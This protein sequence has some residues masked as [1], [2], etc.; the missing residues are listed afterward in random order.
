MIRLSSLAY[1]LRLGPRRLVA[2]LRHLPSFLRLFWRL[3]KDPRVGIG[4]KLLIF[5]L[6]A[7]FL[8]P[9]D[10]LPDVLAGLG[11][12]DDLLLTFVG[13]K[14]FVSLCPPEVVREHVREIA[15]K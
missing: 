15:G 13:L 4:P 8:S 1:L 9:V 7:Y 6:V 3:F 11:H 2:V 5:G 10:L 14:A 12:L